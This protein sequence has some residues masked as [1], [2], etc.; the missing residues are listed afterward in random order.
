MSWS[1]ITQGSPWTLELEKR[2]IALR[3]QGLSAS[4]IAAQ[5]GMT[6]NQI[7]GRLYRQAHPERATYA[8][9]V[10]GSQEY[11]Y[12]GPTTIDRLQAHHDKMDAARWWPEFAN[13]VRGTIVLR[14]PAP[15]Q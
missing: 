13:M 4:V 8:W 15:G 9:R 2:V 6:K 7:I 12:D 1:H 5:L 10:R 11:D 3:G 14:Y